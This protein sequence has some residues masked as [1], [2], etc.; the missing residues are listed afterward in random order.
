MFRFFFFLIIT[1]P[2]FACSPPRGAIVE[3]ETYFNLA[4]A[5]FSGTVLKQAS[6]KNRYTLELKVA[7]V[8]KGQVKDTI[9]VFT[10]SSTC[11]PLGAQATPGSECV[12]FLSEKN[13]VLV[14]ATGSFCHEKG[15]KS[16]DEIHAEFEKEMKTFKLMSTPTGL[17]K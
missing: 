3:R 6:V 15:T 14:D 11:A 9:K 13:E 12:L 5:V 8:W 17:R 16:L 2:A 10:T 4:R 7:R 1:I